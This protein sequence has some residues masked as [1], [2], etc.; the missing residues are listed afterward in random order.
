MQE[1]VGRP[2]IEIVIAQPTGT[3]R[4]LRAPRTIERERRLLALRYLARRRVRLAR[5][6][7]DP[8]NV[9]G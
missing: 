3:G 2:F 5:R 8:A 7:D 9:T 4:R 1:K 6:L